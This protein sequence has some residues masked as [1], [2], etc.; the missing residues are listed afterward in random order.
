[1]RDTMGAEIAA[2][3]VEIFPDV[4]KETHSIFN[5]G[6]TTT[7]YYSGRDLKHPGTLE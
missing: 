6:D 1:M 4:L 3:P 5:V 2:G 7:Y